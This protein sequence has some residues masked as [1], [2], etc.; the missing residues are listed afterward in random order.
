[1]LCAVR[2]A[3]GLQAAKKAHIFEETSVKTIAPSATITTAF[4]RLQTDVDEVFFSTVDQ[5]SVMPNGLQKELNHG[6]YRDYHIR[7]IAEIKVVEIGGW[8]KQD[9]HLRGVQVTSDG[10]LPQVQQGKR[11]IA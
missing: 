7:S 8:F 5:S 3:N 2:T 9:C 11:V 1:M 10:V 6:A 4:T